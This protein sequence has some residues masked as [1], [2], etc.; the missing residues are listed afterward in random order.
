[1]NPLVTVVTPTTGNPCVER[2][3]ESVARQS[4]RN[5]QHL[6]VIDDPQ[7]SPSMR[8]TIKQFG[9]D[10]VEL[11]Y[12]TGKERF[13]GHRIYG[14]SAFLGKGE[15]FC[16]LD[17]DNWFDADHVESLMAVVENGFSWAF[18]LRKI[19]DADGSFVC[20]DDCESLGKWPSIAQ[21]YFIDVGCFFLPRA[22]AVT[23]CPVWYRKAHEPGVLPADRMLTRTLRAISANYETTGRYTL[24][25]RAGSSAGSVRKEFFLRGNREILARY[26]GNLP[27]KEK[28]LAA[29]AVPPAKRASTGSAPDASSGG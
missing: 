12:A 26:D 27:W 2:A 19:V 28:P 14:A 9:A 11:P 4:Y 20:C 5:L 7:C 25:Y 22:L 17:E 1:M 23:T 3:L 21:D 13:N 10:I 8:A 29:A 24:N 16:F 6:V 18:S 15:F